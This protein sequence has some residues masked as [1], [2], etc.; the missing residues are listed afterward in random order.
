MCYKKISPTYVIYLYLEVSYY[1]SIYIK[2]IWILSRTFSQSI[3]TILSRI[4]STLFIY[5]ETNVN[6]SYRIF[7]NLSINEWTIIYIKQIWII[8]LEVSAI[9]Q[10]ISRIE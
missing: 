1:L 6:V 10:Y 5:I 7:H 8:Y 9:Y 4:Q 3:S 2:Q